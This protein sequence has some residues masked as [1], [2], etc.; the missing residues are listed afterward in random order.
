MN[1]CD[2]SNIAQVL[3]D[4]LSLILMIRNQLDCLVDVTPMSQQVNSPVLLENQR[5]QLDA[6]FPFELGAINFENKRI[7]GVYEA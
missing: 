6:Y 3:A 2:T 7:L 1:I 4:P 5:G